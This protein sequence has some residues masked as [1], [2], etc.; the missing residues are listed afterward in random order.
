VAAVSAAID[1]RAAEDSD[2]YR[3]AIASLIALV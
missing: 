2:L 1:Q 3:L